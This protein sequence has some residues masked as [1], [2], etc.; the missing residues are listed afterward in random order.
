MSADIAKNYVAQYLL[1]KKDIEDLKE[2]QERVKVAL[3]PYLDQAETNARGSY[4]L[5]FDEVLEIDGKRYKEL[6]R[7]RK[8]S[9]VLNEERVIRWLKDKQ[10]SELEE[11]VFWDDVV[12]NTG[13]I[14]YVEHIDQD[15]LWDLFAQDLITT[16]ELDSFFDTT[17][18]WAF[19]P[20]KE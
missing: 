19:S 7:V 17:V 8:E 3:A 5:P 16:E 18:S 10:N 1:L 11:N 13:V 6:Q 14:V 9:K 2:K 20:T 15:V 12:S 4:V